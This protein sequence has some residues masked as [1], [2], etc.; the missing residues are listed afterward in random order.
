MRFSRLDTLARTEASRMGFRRF[1]RSDAY[2][3]FVSAMVLDDTL[4]RYV[5][6]HASQQYARPLRAI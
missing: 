5:R 6:L 3:R 1:M 2:F 4:D